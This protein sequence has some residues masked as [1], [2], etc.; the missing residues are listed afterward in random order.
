MVVFEI[1]TCLAL[2]SA[3]YNDKND[4]NDKMLVKN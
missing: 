4:K 2:S 1:F 3:L